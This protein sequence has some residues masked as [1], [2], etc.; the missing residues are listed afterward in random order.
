MKRVILFGTGANG[1]RFVEKNSDLVCENY[2][3]C[4]NDLSKQGETVFGIKIISFHELSLL[5]RSHEVGRIIITT[6]R[7]DEIL[8]QCIQ[9]GIDI[10][11]IYFY[12]IVSNAIKAVQEAYSIA[13]YSQE[14]EE[15]FLKELFG[16]KKD[17]FYVD[18]GALHPFR[19]SNTAWAYEKGWR[20]INIEPNIDG[21]R[22]FE[23]LR[24]R[25]ININ[26]G[27]SDR[28]GVV[29]T[30]Y[31][32]EEPAL[33]G[34]DADMY[35]NIK[36]LEK[37]NVKVRKLS[38]IFSENKVRRIDFLDIDV[39]GM[40]MNVLRSIDFSVDIECILLEQFVNADSLTQTQ[41]YQFLREKG[42]T[43]VAKYGITTI[44]KKCVF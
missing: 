7:V 30:Y 44:Y 15:I 9:N 34:F 32:Y 1:R 39:E 16:D 4:D 37:R 28:E 43:A 2:L 17:G 24:P 23:R 8:G 11:D 42:Y 22:M 12:D 20:G 10:Q 3:F 35:A 14:G 40:E 26:C 13:V 25:D 29:L 27:I 36:V 33:N 5:Y 38:D 19:F 21:F 41:E 31:C 18:V 6:A